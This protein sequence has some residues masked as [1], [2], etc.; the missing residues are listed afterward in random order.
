[1]AVVKEIIA[2]ISG[3]GVCGR[4]KFESGGHRAASVFRRPSRRRIHLACT[5]AVMP[6]L[7][8]AEL[9]DINPA[10]LR[11]DYVSFFRRGRSLMLTPPTS[12]S[13]LPTCRP[14][15]GGMP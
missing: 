15:R 12:L 1:M 7:P 9:P 13:E 10:D 6:E 2:K 3:D 14:A 4:L 5:V 11:I 8:E